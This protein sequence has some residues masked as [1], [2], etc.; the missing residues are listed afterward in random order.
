MGIN[1]I[2]SFEILFLLIDADGLIQAK[3]I[4]YLLYSSDH[5]QLWGKTFAKNFTI[6]WRRGYAQQSEHECPKFSWP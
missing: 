5:Q 6:I 2:Q 3:D 4:S 1:P